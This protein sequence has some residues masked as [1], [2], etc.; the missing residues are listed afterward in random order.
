MASLYGEL[1]DNFVRENEN[2]D[3]AQ[4]AFLKVPDGIDHLIALRQIYARKVAKLKLPSFFACE[5]IA[6]PQKI[7]MEQ[8]SSQVTAQY[9]QQLAGKL[10]DKLSFVDLTAGFGVD[11]SFISREFQS[12]LY[13]E[14]NP[15]L[16]TLAEHNF[17]VLGLRQVQTKC[18]DAIQTLREIHDKKSLI[19]LDPARRD[20][21][22]RKTVDIEECEPNVLTF[23]EELLRKAHAV[24][25]KLSPMLDIRSAIRKL[26]CVSE[27]HAVSVNG[28]LKELLFLLQENCSQTVA[29]AV[30]L[31]KS[32]EHIF[33]CLDEN[34]PKNSSYSNPL[35]YLYE[36]NASIM[37]LSAH[38]QVTDRFNLLK[39]APFS[40]LYTSDSLVTD[41]P[42]RTF[43][44]IKTSS[45]SKKELKETLSGIS[46][47]NIAVR[48]FPLTAEELKKKI[49]LKDGGDS[50]IFGTTTQDDK[51]ILIL[52]K[53]I[54]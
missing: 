2:K 11:F 48:N 51:H 6:Y 37:K 41:F 15:E 50:Y 19:F 39:I 34:Q 40:H 5:D 16:V 13:V 14:Q 8:C 54:Y 35:K 31:S 53:K 32:C 42:G 24:L 4:V 9:K 23:K 43:E 10:H 52:C 36:P 46:Q 20:A 22:G 26:G 27:V 28:E 47:S 17:K 44:V 49:K 25:L 1:L 18:G 7:S 33:F 29:H 3:I 45:L 21:N 30:N 38:N 12:S